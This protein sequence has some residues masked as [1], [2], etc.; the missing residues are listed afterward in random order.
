MKTYGK[1]RA[2]NASP[3]RVW[4]V[5][6]D[7]NNWSR[8]NSGIASA[9]LAGPLVSG[10]TGTTETS[11]GGKHAVTFTDVVPQRGFKLT[12]GGPPG[13]TMT[14]I[15]E[16]EPHGVGS[17]VSQSVALNGPL[18]FLWGPL[19][20]AQMANHFVPVLDDLAKAAET[21]PNS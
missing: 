11:R 4:S 12:T 13:T 16:I 10:A 17:M 5:W 21:A 6:S 18:A 8:W 9:T 7:P 2:T 1:S 15:C 20:G 19:M 14:F 3:E